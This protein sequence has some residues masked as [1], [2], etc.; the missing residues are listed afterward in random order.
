MKKDNNTD[1][2]TDTEKNINAGNDAGIEN[3]TDIH[4]D[5]SAGNDADACADVSALSDSD[6][7]SNVSALNGSDV[8]SENNPDAGSDVP[9][10]N[11]PDAGSDASSENNPHPDTDSADENNAENDAENATDPDDEDDAENDAENGMEND[12][13]PDKKANHGKWL[14][15]TAAA[16]FAVLVCALTVVLA[17]TGNFGA[18]SNGDAEATGRPVYTPEPAAPSEKPAETAAPDITAVPET[19]TP[20]PEVYEETTIFVDGEPEATLASRQAAEEMV[21]NAIN[22]FENLCMANGLITTLKNK[23][24]FRPAEESAQV[25]SYDEAY[26]AFTGGN[27]PLIVESKASFIKF[28]TIAHGTETVESELYYT[29]TRFVEVY[30]RDGKS[31]SVS[32]YTYI[33]GVQTESAVL[34]EKE[35]YPPV[36]EIIITGTREIP[37]DETPDPEF[38]KEDC[39]P[40]ELQ[41]DFPAEAEIIRSFGFYSGVMYNGILFDAGE[42]TCCKA[43]CAGTVLSVMERGNGGFVIDIM[44]ETGFITRYA[45]LETVDVSIGDHAEKGEILGKI[46]GNGLHFEILYESRPR[47]PRIYLLRLFEEA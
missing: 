33:N 3:D 6:A 21:K 15:Y 44:H 2:N 30:G 1:K 22:H 7:S 18:F 32:E 27:S 42:G 13:V 10:E 46:G 28:E 19:E 17:F 16:V 45:G 38:G 24:E 8:P 23:I 41:F 29:G 5:A 25:I 34:E 43:S 11:N 12:D 36:N 31:R 37:E 4:T 35:L 20:Q 47:N 9:S 14:T 26:A 40:T 39:P